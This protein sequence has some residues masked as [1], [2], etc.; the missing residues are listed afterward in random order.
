MRFRGQSGERGGGAAV[1]GEHEGVR[2]EGAED[3]RGELD[4]RRRFGERIGWGTALAEEGSRAV[5]YHSLSLFYRPF[6]ASSLHVFNSERL[7]EREREY[8]HETRGGMRVY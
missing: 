1:Q 2:G 4:R 5:V 8:S 7:K 3:G 6:D